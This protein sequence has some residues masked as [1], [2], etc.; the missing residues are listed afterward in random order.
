M[1]IPAEIGLAYLVVFPV[2]VK[3]PYVLALFSKVQ[4]FVETKHSTAVK[5]YVH[6]QY[7]HQ[8]IHV[9]WGNININKKNS[10]YGNEGCVYKK[11]TKKK[12][13]FYNNAS[14]NW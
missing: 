3:T 12:Q 7:N 5:I 2:T 10:V 11:Y 4:V 13:T 1:Y 6:V 9:T 8:Y 14:K